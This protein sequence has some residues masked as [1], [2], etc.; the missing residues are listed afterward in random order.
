MKNILADIRQIFTPVLRW[1]LGTMILANIAGTMYFALLAVYLADE[2]G[3]SVTQVGMTF[4]LASIVPLMLQIFGGWL[5]DSIGRLRTIALGASVATIGYAMLPFAQTW[6]MATLALTVEYISGSLVGPS[7]SAFI[8]DQSKEEER[9]KVFGIITSMY[10]IVGI[11]GPLLAG[12]L[13]ELFGFRT[14][15]GIAAILYTIA[16]GL[17]IWMAFTFD[18]KLDGV[19]AEKPDLLTLPKSLW[20]LILLIGS[21]GILTWIFLT[22]GIRDISFRMAFEF[23]SLYLSEIGGLSLTQIGS[24]LSIFNLVRTV[25]LMPAGW[26]SDQ[27]GERIAIVIGFVLQAA[28]L[29]IF[30]L[31]NGY[32]GFMAA[33]VILGA[34]FGVS[35]PAYDSLVSKVVPEDKRGI[36][37]GL[38]ATSLGVLSLPAPYLGGLL[39]E[40]F[41]PRTPFQL[42]IGVI[43][44]SIFMVYFKFHREPQTAL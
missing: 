11:V 1:F 35:S 5:S 31:S 41:S 21:G 22:D 28:G 3:A 10:G 24:L 20:Q 44:I 40:N 43:I 25:T 36:A 33:W 38:F 4:T 30:T 42:L 2:V 32:F 6:Q 17:R 27:I 34:G 18:K 13:A 37:F 26:L 8:A 15:L 7:F 12:G 19:E 39:W 23:E 29:F 14:M 9:G 16:A